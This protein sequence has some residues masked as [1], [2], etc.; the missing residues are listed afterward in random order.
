MNIGD[1]AAQDE[2]ASAVATTIDVANRTGF[3]RA[4]SVN[5]VPLLQTTRG[6]APTTESGYTAECPDWARNG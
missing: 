3:E 1:Q 4:A 2:P 5:A 6:E